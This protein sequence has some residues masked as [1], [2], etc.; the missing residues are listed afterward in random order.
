MFHDLLT[1]LKRQGFSI[2]SKTSQAI[3][4]C[5]KVPLYKLSVES[6]WRINQVQ[7]AI[8][9]YL[10][11]PP[12][13]LGA[14]LHCGDVFGLHGRLVFEISN[15]IFIIIRWKSSRARLFE[16]KSAPVYVS[17]SAT[18]HMQSH[19]TRQL[20]LLLRIQYGHFLWKCEFLSQPFSAI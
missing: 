19:A 13:P 5:S 15:H 2:S 20:Q 3:V 9:W 16:R 11:S 10:G 18:A 4:L 14:R 17:N 7:R 12:T 8:L 1:S 6:G